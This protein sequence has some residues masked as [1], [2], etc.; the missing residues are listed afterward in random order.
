MHRTIVAALVLGAAILPVSAAGAG[1]T[2]EP[3]PVWEDRPEA[4]SGEI[5]PALLDDP[6]YQ[7]TRARVDRNVDP[8]RAYAR[9]RPDEFAGL[10]VDEFEGLVYVAFTDHRDRHREALRAAAPDP[11]AVR[12]IAADHSLAELRAVQAQI[13]RDNLELEQL[14]IRVSAVGPDERVNRV[15]VMVAELD[16]ETK[17]EFCRRY[18]PDLFVFEEGVVRAVAA[19]G[20]GVSEP[21]DEDERLSARWGPDDGDDGRRWAPVLLTGVT[22]TALAISLR[23]RRRVDRAGHAETD[24]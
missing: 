5:D 17:T 14:G 9:G 18:G 6:S 21:S 4:P 15:W 24:T 2:C 16:E 1:V 7:R 10:F 20:G 11:E 19:P 22:A 8:V 13:G 23:L 12:V 3:P